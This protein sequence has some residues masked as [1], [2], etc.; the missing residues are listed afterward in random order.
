[1]EP[2]VTRFI[3]RLQLENNYSLVADINEESETLPDEEQ[4]ITALENETDE[5]RRDVIFLEMLDAIEAYQ[6][7]WIPLG[8]PFQQL[9]L[10]T[11]EKGDIHPSLSVAPPLLALEPIAARVLMKWAGLSIKVMVVI[12]DAVPPGLDLGYFTQLGR[13]LREY[14]D[15]EGEVLEEE[16]TPPRKKKKRS[17]PIH[18]EVV[19]IG[20]GADQAINRDRLRQIHCAFNPPGK[21][22]VLGY[23]LDLSSQRVWSSSSL[24]GRKNQRCFRH[25]LQHQGQTGPEIQE[26]L[27]RYRVSPALVVGGVVMALVLLVSGRLLIFRLGLMDEARILGLIDF[28]A[29]FMAIGFCLT[30]P[31]LKIKA[32]KQALYTLW[33]YLPFYYGL[34]LLPAW[35]PNLELLGVLG[36]NTA[37]LWIFTQLVG[38]SAELD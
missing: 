3:H 29:P 4:W 24:W 28:L 38:L 20:Q 14:L 33:G 7:S 36:I 6:Q 12:E 13:R 9:A 32:S 16:K 25:A 30:L 35:P 11:E 2:F 37:M 23:I 34:S 5:D 8:G 17:L 21:I 22:F 19:V 10:P 31:R 27:G 26:Q 18:F 1:M 15:A